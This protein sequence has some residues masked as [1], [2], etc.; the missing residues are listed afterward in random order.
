[1]NL[2]DAKAL[3]MEFMDRHGLLT[4]GWAF[5]FDNAKTRAGSCNYDQ[6]TISMSK[7]LPGV[8]GVSGVTDTMLHE[9]AHALVGPEHGHDAAWKAKALEIGCSGQRC[10]AY[11]MKQAPWKVTCPCGAVCTTRH[12]VT[13]DI[14][15]SKVCKQCKNPLTARNTETGE[16][17]AAVT[18]ATPQAPQE[19]PEGYKFLVTCPCGLVH[20]PRKVIR[21]ELRDTPRNCR[22]C[23]QPIQI[24]EA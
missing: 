14:L 18:T 9:I 5:V 6:K 21:K 17:R 23:Q 4:R 15:V 24:I 3:A 16:V 1:M 13:W 2:Q 12:K 8:S 11:V 7:Y 10:H 19:A 20:C 22:A